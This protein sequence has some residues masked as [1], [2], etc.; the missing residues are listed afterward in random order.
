VRRGD[1]RSP[2]RFVVTGA[3]LALAVAA[4]AAAHAAPPET[5]GDEIYRLAKE[6]L[7]KGSFETS[8]RLFRVLSEEPRF[9]S[10]ARFAFNHAQA[11]RFAGNSGEA[12]FWYGRYLAASPSA[13]D[14]A[15]VKTEIAKLAQSSPKSLR[16]EALKRAR[17]D[18]ARVLADPE[19]RRAL[20]DCAHVRLLVRFRHRTESV[21]G[22]TYVFHA[23][24]VFFELKDEADGP[25]GVWVSADEPIPGPDDGPPL[26]MIPPG[27]PF[28]VPLSSDVGGTPVALVPP[29]PPGFPRDLVPA[30]WLA[31]TTA[32]LDRNGPPLLLAGASPGEVLSEVRTGRQDPLV[33]LSKKRHEIP[34]VATPLAFGPRPA[35]ADSKSYAG[36]RVLVV[37]VSGKDGASQRWAAPPA[38]F[39]VVNAFGRLV[40]GERLAVRAD[41]QGPSLVLL[42]RK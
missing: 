31:E 8:V 9:E 19:L 25:S 39:T 16:T 3:I 24:A 11:S 2:R 5:P 27:R 28:R 7:A 4:A 32:E 42:D 34:S 13:P 21:A 12:V 40:P 22:T 15:T 38:A 6:A 1:P 23:R 20:D 14:A 26:L 10:D 33:E 37:E 18:W 29:P 35:S 36:L 41:G 17:A 30:G